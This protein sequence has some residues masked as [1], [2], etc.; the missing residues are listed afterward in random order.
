[1][2]RSAPFSRAAKRSPAF[3]TFMNSTLAGLAIAI[4][5]PQY[6][7]MAR[8]AA[9]SHGRAGM[10]NDTLESPSTVRHLNVRAHQRTV[11]SVSCAAAASDA[12]AIVRPSTTISSLVKPNF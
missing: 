11:A 10:P 6:W 3:F 12:T 8:K 9:F 1:M 2:K 7:A 4:V 5:R